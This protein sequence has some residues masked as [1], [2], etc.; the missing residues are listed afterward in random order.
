[1]TTTVAPPFKA[2]PR[3]VYWEVVSSPLG[4]F[5]L[6]GD[7]RLLVEAHLPGRWTERT[8][9]AAWQR[10]DGAVAPAA[11]QLDAYFRG[12]RREF[13]LD[14]APTGTP[15]QLRVW[16]G[17][18][19]IPYGSTATYGD[20]AAS[21]GNPKASRA[22]GMANNRNP[23]ALFIPCHRVIGANGS[24]TGYGG[25]LEMKTWLLEHERRNTG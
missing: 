25:G 13:D 19:D 15:F 22:V 23:I 9:P 20:V 21:V 18:C 16:A 3:S 17:L 6:A 1:M 10:R 11:E 2:A 7:G 12:S 4:D 5:L 14:F 8:V 24:L